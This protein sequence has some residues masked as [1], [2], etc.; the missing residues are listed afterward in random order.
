MITSMQALPALLLCNTLV[1]LGHGL[2]AGLRR[3]DMRGLFEAVIMLLCPLVG[4]V[5]V[6]GSGI[7]FRL[8]GDKQADTRGDEQKKHKFF[9][10]PA[11]DEAAIV[12]M[13]ELLLVANHK[14]RRKALL[15]TIGGKRAVSGALFSKALENEDAETSHYS[16]T[17]VMELSAQHHTLLQRAAVD[18]ERD[19]TK[20]EENIAYIQAAH[21]YDTSGLLTEIEQKK[22]GYLVMQLMEN[23]R[24]VHP[25]ALTPELYRMAAD[26][27]LRMGELQPALQ[28]AAEGCQRFA[29]NEGMYLTL[30]KVYYT[31]GDAERLFITME[32][33][34]DA[35][36]PL[37]REGALLVRYFQGDAAG[38]ADLPEEV[39]A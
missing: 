29:E 8:I 19:R 10:A 14:D 3:R 22:Y 15:Q 34:I 5:F 4:L 35:R 6:L 18:Y 31:L 28:W 12:P 1:A 11:K 39:R 25:E 13:E 23:L 37:T 2:W 27:M 30:M 32:N 21:A 7:A 33:L 24:L 38:E 20:A 36:I 16:A 9:F 26:T 17:F